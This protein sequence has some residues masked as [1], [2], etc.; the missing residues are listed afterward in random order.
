MTFGNGYIEWDCH[1]CYVSAFV[2]YLDISEASTQNYFCHFGV[3]ECPESETTLT[4][5]S[6]YTDYSTGLTVNMSGTTYK[7]V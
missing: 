2:L 1:G 7:Y 6:D 5:Q 4:M 3:F